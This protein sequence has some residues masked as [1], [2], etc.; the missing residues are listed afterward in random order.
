MWY[1]HRVPAQSVCVA[2]CYF[3]VNVLDLPFASSIAIPYVANYEY[4]SII[5]KRRITLPVVYSR[6]FASKVVF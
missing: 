4:K 3:V 5:N 2:D 1:N 6:S